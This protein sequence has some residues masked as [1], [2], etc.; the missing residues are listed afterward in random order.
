MKRDCENCKH[1]EYIAN[2]EHHAIA[3]SICGAD[4]EMR[5]EKECGDY[6]LR[7]ADVYI[8][9]ENP[10][11]G[12]SKITQMALGKGYKTKDATW[13]VDLESRLY[14]LC[15]PEKLHGRRAELVYVDG[16]IRLE[17]IL[18]Y[19]AV[20]VDHDLNRIKIA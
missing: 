12:M 14:A 20:V 6:N 10:H 13:F 2:S 7:D 9:Y 3:N 8:V 5:L 18:Q 1:V 17:K 16:S 11:A 15:T 4:R 19:V